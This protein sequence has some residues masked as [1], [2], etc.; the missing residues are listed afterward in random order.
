MFRTELSTPGQSVELCADPA[1]SDSYSAMITYM[2]RRDGRSVL[3]L[4][5]G[6][7]V[8]FQ[9]ELGGHVATLHHLNCTKRARLG[10]HAPADVKISR[11]K[12]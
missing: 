3:E 11:G 4:T 10:I 12:K 8:A 7:D 2:G 1:R 9:L 6:D 5:V